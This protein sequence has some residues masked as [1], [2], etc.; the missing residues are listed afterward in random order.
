MERVDEIQPC[1]KVVRC[2]V[3]GT[4]L[5]ESQAAYVQGFPAH[6]YH[7]IN[8]V[9]KTVSEKLTTTMDLMNRGCFTCTFFF[10]GCNDC[11]N[12]EVQS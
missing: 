8:E 4:Y 9:L 12:E 1:V 6:R 10:P 11:M 3:C 7:E 2:T 5:P